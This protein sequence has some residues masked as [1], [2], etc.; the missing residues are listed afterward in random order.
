MA[1]VVNKPPA[2]AGDTGDSD[3]IPGSGRSLE[4]GTQPTPVFLPRESHGQRNLVG[5]SPWGL[6]E[7]DTTEATQH[8]RTQVELKFNCICDMRRSLNK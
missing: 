2:S 7:L 8:T 4:E 6:K 3:A 5:Y 1:L